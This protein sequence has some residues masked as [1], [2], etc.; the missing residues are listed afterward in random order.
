MILMVESHPQPKG[1]KYTSVR[2]VFQLPQSTYA[3]MLFR[4][5]TKSSSAGTYQAS[6]SKNVKEGKED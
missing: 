2:F 4:E 3:T 1:N 6:L 5:L